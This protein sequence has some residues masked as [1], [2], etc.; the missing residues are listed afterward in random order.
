MKK[1]LFLLALVLVILASGAPLALAQDVLGVGPPPPGLVPCLG[2]GGMN[3]C[4]WDQLFAL[5]KNVLN[6]FIILGTAATSL[7]IAYAGFLYLRHASNPG[8]RGEAKALL[9]RAVVGL[10]FILAA[11]LIVKTIIAVLL[12]PAYQAIIK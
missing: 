12:K 2:T 9:W 3:E 1:F 8:K 5:A 4:G 6:F 7:T 11:A 10:A